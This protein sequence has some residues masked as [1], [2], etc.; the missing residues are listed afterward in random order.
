[1]DQYK[2]RHNW[3]VKKLAETYRK[4]I[5]QRI[6][7]NLLDIQ[8]LRLLQTQPLW[9]YMIKKQV[10]AKFN[11]RLRH[12][13]LYPMLNSLEK[14][15]FLTCARHS[16][17]GRIRKVYSITCKGEHCLEAYNSVLREQLS[18]EDLK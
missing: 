4:G 7:K 3:N 15:S 16:K 13:A 5:V 6:T 10:E 8:I 11:V 17:G 1:M 14:Q 12:G 9:G 2:K 18:R